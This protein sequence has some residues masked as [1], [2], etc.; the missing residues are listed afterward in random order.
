M[1][2]TGFL[3]DQFHS[4]Q[5]ENAALIEKIIDQE[6]LI[7]PK[8]ESLF[9]HILNVHHIWNCRWNGVEPESNKWDHLP[10][11]YWEELNRE[12]SLVSLELLGALPSENDFTAET[13]NQIMMAQHILKHSV[14]HRG[15]IIAQ[16]QFLHLEIPS[17]EFAYIKA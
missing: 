8:I 12:N 7:V 1:N 15:Q 5:D 16:M 3:Y 9:S 2:L 4:N 11:R 14:Y 10:L 6:A 13:L 17:T